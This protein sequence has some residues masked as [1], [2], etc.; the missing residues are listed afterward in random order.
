MKYVKFINLRI[1]ICLLIA[2]ACTQHVFAETLKDSLILKNRDI[3]VGEIKSLD[4]GVLTIETD[5]SE[6]DFLVEWTGVKEIFCKSRFLITLRNGTRLNGTFYTID[7]GKTLI[8]N[9]YV[10]HKDTAV[11]QLREVL[12]NVVFLK[13]LKS[14]FWSRASANIDMGITMTRAN[15]LRQL[16]GSTKLGYL[17]DKWSLDMYYNDL[18]SKQDSISL[19]RRTDAGINYVYYLQRDWFSMASITFLSNTEQALALRSTGKLGMGKYFLHTNR[20]YW[21]S[22]AGLS[23]NMEKFSNETP[24]RNS[25]EAYVGSEINLFD[26]GDFNFFNS[27]FVFRSLT[28][29]DRWRSDIRLDAKYDFAKDFYAKIGMTLN[30][31]NRPAVAGNEIDYVFSFSVGWELD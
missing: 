16:T 18:R 4:K 20:R 17:A 23:F 27:V 11:L 21:S 30:Y 7:S 22:N 15:N 24:A 19:T 14:D 10:S 29:S 26:I 6:K 8:I 2:G 28:K 13:G 25:L 3:I 31:D 1:C 12:G 9:G 5:Y